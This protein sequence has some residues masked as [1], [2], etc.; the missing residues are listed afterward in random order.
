MARN[1]FPPV[2]ALLLLVGTSLGEP[3]RGRD[4]LNFLAVNSFT[5]GSI[6]SS[7]QE[8]F[9]RSGVCFEID[10]APAPRNSLLLRQ[11][12]VDGE[13][14][15]IPDYQNTVGNTAIMVPEPIIEGYGLLVAVSQDG[16]DENPADIQGM[17]V[18]RGVVWQNHVSLPSSGV[19]EVGDYEALMTMLRT[20]RV[21]AVLI[22]NVNLALLR[23]PEESLFAKR[24]T[25]KLQAH[26][27]LHASQAS[28]LPEI[29]TAIRVW[30]EKHAPTQGDY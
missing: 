23:T 19:S 25:P 20:G 18:G 30:K 7:L 16:L 3:A 22:D 9:A 5:F 24:V 12:K 13:L 1:L 6:I 28:L 17:A 14:F 15:R 4:C 29:D 27:F 21:S 8:S 26:L 2:F 10:H 11:G